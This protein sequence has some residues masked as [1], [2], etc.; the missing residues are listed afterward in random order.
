MAS[1]LVAHLLFIAL[2]FSGSV[3]QA[4]PNMDPCPRTTESREWAAAC[5]EHTDSGRQ[6][7]QAFRKKLA[8]NRKEYAVIVIPAPPAIVSVNRQGK[9]VKLRMAHLRAAKFDFEP[10]DGEGD[11]VRF[12]Y[13]TKR[14]RKAPAFKCGF[15]RSGKFEVLVPPI[16]DVCDPFNNGSALVCIDCASHCDSGDCH[17]SDITGDKGLVINQNNEVLR[18]IQLPSLPL[19]AHSSPKETASP[20]CRPRPHDPFWNL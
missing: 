15:Y 2:I 11:I 7:K 13:L 3:A 14:A 17:E 16:Y 9:V 19:C 18:T 10:G 4:S 5:F 20:L 6:V 12:G 8:F 1:P